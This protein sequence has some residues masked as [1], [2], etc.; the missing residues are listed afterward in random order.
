[1]AEYLSKDPKGKKRWGCSKGLKEPIITTSKKVS[2]RKIFDMDRNHNLI[3]EEM[4]KLNPN[5]KLI[6]FEV[7]RNEWTNMPYIHVLMKKN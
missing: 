7:K 5:Y 1:M 4:K 6:K 2:K 3:E